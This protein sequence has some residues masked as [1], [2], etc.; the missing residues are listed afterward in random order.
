[1]AS[2]GDGRAAKEDLGSA[3]RS[4]R[5]TTWEELLN[6]TNGE[7]VWAATRYT[8]PPRPLAAPTITHRGVY[9][10]TSPEIVAAA[11]RGTSLKQGPESIG[12]GPLAIR[13]T[14]EWEPGRAVAP[15]RAH[16]R[17]R[18]RTP[19]T[20]EDGQEGHHTKARQGRLQLCKAMPSNLRTQLLGQDGREGRCHR[21]AGQRSLRGPE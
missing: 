3:I 13:F 10:L 9:K 4:A 2:Q 19:R 15:A 11:S 7:G 12:I 6:K 1:M 17:L 18:V 16:T 21:H 8:R 5:Q 20:A 14:R